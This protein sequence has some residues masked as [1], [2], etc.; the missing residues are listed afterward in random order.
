MLDKLMDQQRWSLLH[1]TP[2]YRKRTTRVL[3]S[4]T[5]WIPLRHEGNM[6]L[7]ALESHGCDMKLNY[8]MKSNLCQ[9]VSQIPAK[10]L[11][12]S[13]FTNSAPFHARRVNWLPCSPTN[14]HGLCR[15]DKLF[16]L[17][18]RSF[19]DLLVVRSPAHQ[20]LDS[21][22]FGPNCTKQRVVTLCLW[23]VSQLCASVGRGSSESKGVQSWMRLSRWCRTWY[24]LHTLAKHRFEMV[25]RSE[26]MRDNSTNKVHP[27]WREAMRGNQFHLADLASHNNAFSMLIK[28]TYVAPCSML[29]AA[30][31]LGACEGS[32]R[33]PCTHLSSWSLRMSLQDS[34]NLCSLMA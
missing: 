25:L 9:E 13:A 11:H 10:L 15:F 19:E 1:K 22:W 4:P 31:E 6:L 26:V 8:I 17:M 34:L 3:F 27:E 28:I 7:V 18:E 20:C 12:L 2:R 16:V 33:I 29:L 14:L 23:Q 32:Q 5:V 21:E 30:L 24:S